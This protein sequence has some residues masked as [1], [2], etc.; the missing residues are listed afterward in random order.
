MITKF[1]D[2]WKVYGTKDDWFRCRKKPIV[3]KAV[4]MD[5]DFEV[6]TPEGIVKGKVGDYLLEG[7]AQEVY[8]CRKDIF[9]RT[10]NKVR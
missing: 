5:K 6:Q 2:A 9:E 1:A 4:R 7:V 10:Y 8:P 3:I